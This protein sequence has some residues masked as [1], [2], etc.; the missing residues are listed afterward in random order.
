MYKKIKIYMITL[1]FMVTTSLVCYAK[2]DVMTS[3][4]VNTTGAEKSY[5]YWVH[6]F[7]N[8]DDLNSLNPFY[9]VGYENTNFEFH[10]EICNRTDTSLVI[11]GSDTVWQGNVNILTVEAPKAFNDRKSSFLLKNVDGVGN[12]LEP[13]S[14]F[15]VEFIWEPGSDLLPFGIYTFQTEYVYPI[16][17]LDTY[18]PSITIEI[19]GPESVVNQ[20][21]KLYREFEESS[22]A[23][24]L[25][26]AEEKLLE[27][28]QVDRTSSQA[29]RN[30]GVIYIEK[31][32]Y[33]KALGFY[34]E[35]VSF[36]ETGQDTYYIE[37]LNYS[38]ETVEEIVDGIRG[39]IEAVHVLSGNTNRPP[40]FE[41]LGSFTVQTGTTL[42]FTITA[43]DAEGDSIILSAGNLPIGASFSDNTDGTGD[44]I[45]TPTTDQVGDYRVNFTADDG[46]EG[47]A[48]TTA[49][50]TV[51]DE[52][53]PANQPPVFTLV[54]S[55]EVTVENPLTFNVQASDPDGD[56][57][58]LSSENIPA[59]ATF[60]D[61][62]NNSGTFVWTP[63]EGQEGSYIITFTADDGNGGVSTTTA[64]ITVLPGSQ[65]AIDAIIKIGPKV[66]NEKSKGQWV[67]CDIELPSGYDVTDI[68]TGSIK[69]NGALSIVGDVTVK[70]GAN[71]LGVKF[72]KQAITDLLPVGENIR[73]TITGSVGSDR[74]EGSCFVTVI[75][76]GK[77]TI[78]PDKLDMNNVGK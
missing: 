50:I 53:Q 18:P 21:D 46:N 78:Q 62:G 52:E 25:L 45:W 40:V 32:E 28:L 37:W 24:D 4:S 27:L 36:L 55:Q 67:N 68:D 56:Q 43:S 14:C 38:P 5:Y 70:P 49:M 44:F 59:G 66:I 51:Y 48:T 16:S 57:L 2:T 20:L 47:T 73:I 11:S 39:E 42:A 34:N 26:K 30:L 61:N 54:P 76:K 35:A 74:F 13:D 65:A 33:D 29:K 41:D 22:V 23:N 3:L 9:V 7:A 12:V 60:T 17:N 58:I 19:K 8:S 64:S 71:I 6:E 77:D 63:A 72:L 10:F 1:L 15:D 75:K 69:L 31:G